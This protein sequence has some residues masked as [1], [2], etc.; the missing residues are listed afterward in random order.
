MKTIQATMVV[1]LMATCAFAV[2]DPDPNSIGLYFDENADVTCLDGVALHEL[3]TIFI[4]LT[5][6]TE[7]VIWGFELGYDL[8]GDALCVHNEINDSGTCPTT[9]DPGNIIWG[10]FSPLPTSEATILATQI[11]LNMDSE[12]G[13]VTFHLHGSNPSSVD[14][15]YPT[16][17]LPDFEL[18][19]TGLSTTGGPSAQ[20]NGNCGVV[21]AERMSFDAVKS[22]YREVH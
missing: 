8:V 17:L 21:A 11:Y 14:P 3:V 13:P 10:F 20:I 19:V 5:R 1:L 16:L 4:I 18:M 9:D 2:V 15:A 22:L 7:D 6:P 12:L